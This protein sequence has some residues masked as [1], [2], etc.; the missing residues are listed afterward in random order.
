M[1]VFLFLLDIE[2]LPKLPQ[3]SMYYKI[4][5]RVLFCLTCRC[6]ALMSEISQHPS[7]L[8]DETT[9]PPSQDPLKES[10]PSRLVPSIG[11]TIRHAKDVTRQVQHFK[12][13]LASKIEELQEA[14][15]DKDIHKKRLVILASEMRNLTNEKD[16]LKSQVAE[17][18]DKLNMHLDLGNPNPV[19]IAGMLVEKE[20]LLEQLN[21]VKKEQAT[22]ETAQK[23][24]ALTEETIKIKEQIAKNRE[25][26]NSANH[27]AEENKQKQQE[28]GDA[29]EIL[30]NNARLKERNQNLTAEKQKLEDFLKFAINPVGTVLGKLLSKPQANDTEPDAEPNDLNAKSAKCETNLPR[31]MEK[32]KL[33]VQMNQNL[34]KVLQG[35]QRSMR[36]NALNAEFNNFFIQ[37]NLLIET[38][39]KLQQREAEIAQELD[40]AINSFKVYAT[41]HDV[42]KVQGGTQKILGGI[43]GVYNSMQK[44]L[45][46]QAALKHTPK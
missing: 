2:R 3:I 1:Q 28:L 15:K 24:K 20:K 38:T 5:A 46:E 11:A 29:A 32:I 10:I 45:E 39:S 26:I 12:E 44:L 7:W 9:A 31:A 16:S 41:V 23:Y 22:S 36:D 19:K 35:I 30:E 13:E 21:N 34:Q 6:A 37:R 27:M 40:A 14:T 43:H 42:K 25:A 4:S 18:F 33:Q 17:I 8:S